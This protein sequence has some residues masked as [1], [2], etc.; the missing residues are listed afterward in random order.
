MKDCSPLYGSMAIESFAGFLM[1]LTFLYLWMR[2]SFKSELRAPTRAVFRLM[3][4]SAKTS[5]NQFREQMRTWTTAPDMSLQERFTF[6][7]KANQGI[8]LFQAIMA[9]VSITRWLHIGNVNG[10]RYLGYSITCPPMQAELVLMIAP[11]VPCFRITFVFTMLVTFSMLITGWLAS[12]RAEELFSCDV[13]SLLIASRSL[14]GG[15]VDDACFEEFSMKFWLIAPSVCAQVFLTCLH[16]PYLGTLYLCNGGGSNQA[17]PPG[18]LRLLAIV[19]FTWLGFPIWWFLSYEGMA[20]IKDTRMNAVV[21]ALLNVISKGAYSF[22]VLAMVK[23]SQI[24]AAEDGDSDA[25][26]QLGANR[27]RK[28]SDASV[29]SLTSSDL[30]D[31]A[32][33]EVRAALSVTAWL[34]RFLQNF[35][36]GDPHDAHVPDGGLP[37]QVGTEEKLAS[38]DCK[39]LTEDTSGIHVTEAAPSRDPPSETQSTVDDASNCEEPEITSRELWEQLEP[40]FRRF[41]REA[42]ITPATFHVM[43]AERKFSLR[44][45]FDK[46]AS[47]VLVSKR[48]RRMRSV[49]QWAAGDCMTL[50]QATDEQL[51]GEVRRRM[52]HERPAASAFPSAFPS[53]VE[54]THR[55]GSR[56]CTREFAAPSLNPSPQPDPAATGFLRT[57]VI[58]DQISEAPSVGCNAF[59]SIVYFTSES[60][61]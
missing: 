50:V 46:V 59:E 61:P 31:G 34:V 40:M 36:D 43:S 26:A 32:P 4:Y 13:E 16:I 21:F 45:K 52:A 37:Q 6:C 20:V 3:R 33:A 10:I 49:P 30:D 24:R 35:D 11:V 7:R 44:E 17:L 5:L 60:R 23:R 15:V 27:P 57:V 2:I 39:V 19:A 48:G 41:L 58:S 14:L 42:G 12:I 18:Y 28:G 55:Q 8:L 38:P 1:G 51:M 22:Q 25:A 56:K 29:S 53:E 54:S 47:A 9:F